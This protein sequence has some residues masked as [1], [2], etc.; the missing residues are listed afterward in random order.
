MIK[1]IGLTSLIL[2][3]LVSSCGD[4]L[5]IPKPPTYLRT[6]F[7]K[8]EYV[9][10]NDATTYSFELSKAYFQKSL[11]YQGKVTN[12]KEITLGPLNGIL[13]L[14]YYPIP[15]RD[16]LVR[17]IN[18]SNDK[19]DEHQIKATGIKDQ[20][21]IFRDKKVYGTLFEFEGNVATN[22]QFYLTDSTSNFI[23]GE[24]LMNCRPNYDSLRPS[25][26][27]LKADLIHL[28]ETLEWKK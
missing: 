3:F 28:I 5:L 21:F 19:V 9:K 15:N 25:L 7:P 22:F 8:H 1:I 20:N 13:Y 16:T 23:R 12:H 14:N 24:V 27:Y 18:L 11:S 4:E 17:Y 6:N 2:A 10:V 26:N